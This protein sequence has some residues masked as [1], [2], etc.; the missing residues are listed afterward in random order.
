[1]A[2][3]M[4]RPHSDDQTMK[5][6]SNKAVIAVNQDPNGKPGYR[7]FKEDDGQD[8]H[9]QFWKGDLSNDQFAFVILNAGKT[10]RETCFS[11][12]DFFIDEGKSHGD[13]A[14]DLQDLWDEKILLKSVKYTCVK[15]PSHGV[16]MFRVG[17][18]Q[19]LE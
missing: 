19:A 1:M 6:I 7:L 8:R 2:Y 14:W 10:E 18:L 4:L 9:I 13:R 3:L 15:V 11:M 16:H 12:K 5:I 17:Q